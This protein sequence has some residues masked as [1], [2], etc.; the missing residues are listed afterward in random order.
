MKTNLPVRDL[1]CGWGGVGS[2]RVSKCRGRRKYDRERP[3]GAS[4]RKSRAEGT[5][6]WAWAKL[7]NGQTTDSQAAQLD[8][9]KLSTSNRSAADKERPRGLFILRRTMNIK[10]TL[11]VCVRVG[12]V[13]A[14][15]AVLTTVGE[16][17]SLTDGQVSEASEEAE[18]VDFWQR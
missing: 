7:W 8:V 14:M 12:L 11:C 2:R 10:S 15:H 17:H 16:L 9:N 6:G 18:L 13:S 3:D 4:V 5:E 1:W